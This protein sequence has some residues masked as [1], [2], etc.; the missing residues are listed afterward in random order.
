MTKTLL[1]LF[2]LHFCISLDFSAQVTNNRIAGS[3]YP[4]STSPDYLYLTSENYSYSEKIALQSLQGVLAKTK[5]E[6]L[7]DV[8]GHKTIVEREGIYLDQSYYNNF[9]GLLSHFAARLDGYILCES[10][11][12]STNV[13]I[14]L[15]GIL[16]AV[17]IPSDLEP[18]AKSVGLNLLLDVRDKDERWALQN[19]GNDFSKSIATY[20]NCSDDRGLFMGDYT[21]FTGAFQ[22]W[23]NEATGTLAQAA[24]NRMD[25]GATFF[26]WGAGEY[27]TVEQLSQK[28]M[29]IHP[30]DFS[31]NL[32]TLTNI[33][34]VLPKQKTPISPFEV[35]EDVHTVCFVIS[36]GDNI[37]WLSGTSDNMNNWASPNRSRLD[38]GWTISPA[39]V[40]LAPIIYKKYLENCLTTPEGRNYLI[41]GPSGRGYYFPG[42]F[43]DLNQ[44]CQLLND[45]MKK[46]D[47]GIV[48][49]IDV[50]NGPHTPDEYLK[51]SNIDA[52]FY[53]TYGAN[54][55]GMDGKISW[56]KDKP[57]IGGRYTLWGTLSS[58]NSLADKLNRESTD[59]Y[60]E[61][62]YSL[63]P[64][65]VWSRSV[66]DVLECINKLGPNVRVVAPDEFVWLLRKNIKGLPLGNGN[67]L[68][69]EY[70]KGTFFETLKY[71]QTDSKIDFDWGSLS[72]N[73][74]KL[75]NDEFSIRWTGQ[76][77]PIYSEE[78]T[79]YLSSDDGVKM[80]LDGAVIFD[81]QSDEGVS[82]HSF[83][84]ALNAA[85][86][87]DISIE[88][89]ERSG[90]AYCNFEWESASQI[91]QTV[92][93]TQLYSRP[94]P[95][96]DLLTFYDACD[97]GGYSAGLKVGE[98]KLSDL[99]AMGIY[100]NTIA[101]LKVAK[102][103]KVILYEEDYF[104]GA[105]TEISSD[106]SCLDDWRDRTS[107][108]KIK[109]NGISDLDGVYFLKNRRS[110]YYMDVTGGINGVGEGA[111]V[112]QWKVTPNINQQFKFIHLGDGTYSILAM[113]SQKSIEVKDFD[114]NNGGNVQQWTYYGSSNQ[115][116]IVVQSGSNGYYNL[117]AAHSGKMIE[118]E[119]PQLEANVR[120]WTNNDQ[121]E[122]QW[123]LIAVDDVKNGDGDGLKAEYYNG[124]NFDNLRIT[125]IDK[126]I[127]F[128][129]GSSRPNAWTNP[130]NFSISWTGYLE[131]RS[132]GNY[133][134]Y[135]NSDNGR[136][137]WVNDQ[138]IIDKW[139]NDYGVEYVGDIALIA[140]QKYPI[141]L[142]YFETNGGASCKLE[143]RGNQ[144]GR[145]VVPQSQ[146]YSKMPTVGIHDV[147]I[148]DVDIY[149]NPI[150]DHTMFI[151][152]NDICLD[153]EVILS[154]YNIG[155]V[156]VYSCKVFEEQEINIKE[157]SAGAYIV[158]VSNDEFSIN[159]R[160]VIL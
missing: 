20:Q 12:S 125:I 53:Y 133:T 13:A 79:F 119:T 6:I 67:G 143:W 15:S 29:M 48:N 101:S 111:N 156:R 50:D 33:P 89:T 70:F 155:G 83:T 115:K 144:Q 55:T 49:I 151:K 96:T 65:H 98:Y 51:Q 106:N 132:S 19:Y 36:D 158:N 126:A 93:H 142:E 26:G 154:I 37:Q 46:A 157:I 90:D 4:Y 32:S 42:I 74:S 134:F 3:P 78:Y 58:P 68:K 66:D 112:Q 120:Q 150:L 30:S 39:F 97:F 38:L 146:L 45:Y 102:G 77:Q 16:N 84:I 116:F 56:Y 52:L 41:A 95:S 80:T 25:N 109:T 24:Y 88:Y 31:P 139:I 34:T 47:L 123:E 44:E 131:P 130:D 141:K 152:L 72:P 59:I 108:L 138:L 153:K 122:G 82:A 147:H 136:R 23:D 11:Q 61:G 87:Y 9:P 117:L 129:W 103:F 124:I 10:K 140:N 71:T 94:Q 114:Q 54:Y 73:K 7:R 159:K 21:S 64:V 121:I 148:K 22:F 137:L 76:L 135:I 63:I 100:D 91:R 8:H 27:A 75:G 128:N 160:I 43:P 113:H 28:S 81:S 5:P 1:L 92:P 62:G 18:M 17:A 2:L 14:S 118:V 86:K 99:N 85:Q 105:S 57:S 40:E 149:P 60:S 104:Q 69:G 107:S 145:E 110:N 127:D 35:V